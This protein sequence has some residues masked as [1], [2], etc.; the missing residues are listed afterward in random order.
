MLI[1]KPIDDPQGPPP[2]IPG[3]STG[4]SNSPEQKRLPVV[5]NTE[6]DFENSGFKR[7][8]QVVADAEP[9]H[10]TAKRCKADRTDWGGN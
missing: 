7:T 6:P 8:M 10:S 3:P 9:K 5:A 1:D 2:V 4:V